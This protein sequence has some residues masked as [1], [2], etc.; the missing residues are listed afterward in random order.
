MLLYWKIAYIIIIINVIINI[1]II[2]WYL[3]RHQ[4]YRMTVYFCAL[5]FFLIFC[6]LSLMFSDTQ[7][8]GAVPRL[9]R[10]QSQ[11]GRVPGVSSDRVASC[12][13]R[14][15]RWSWRRHHCRIHAAQ[16]R[17]YGR[18]H[19]CRTGELTGRT[20]V[21][22]DTRYGVFSAQWLPYQLFIIK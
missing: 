17:S 15:M 13:S 12:S 20:A 1:I 19:T 10:L 14:S 4:Y 3:V 8:C 16:L 7:H 6:W 5:S 21:S 9:L 11:R 18:H 2:S 22:S